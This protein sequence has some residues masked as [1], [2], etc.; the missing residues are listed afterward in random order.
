MRVYSGKVRLN[1]DLR[2]EVRRDRITAPEVLVLRA[3][4]GGDAVVDLKY[5]DD[6]D[7]DETRGERERLQTEY[8]LNPSEDGNVVTKLFGPSHLSLPLKATGAPEAKEAEPK[9]ASKK[10]RA[11]DLAA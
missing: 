1:G 8:V 7:D 10:L 6:L 5:I 11:E 3:L 9:P 2:W 4:H